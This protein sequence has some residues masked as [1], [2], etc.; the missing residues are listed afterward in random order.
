M[1]SEERGSMLHLQAGGQL[2]GHRWR[3]VNGARSVPLPTD[4]RTA[5]AGR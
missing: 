1:P 5:L 4:S 3:A 2:A